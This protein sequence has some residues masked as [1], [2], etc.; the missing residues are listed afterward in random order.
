MVAYNAGAYTR[1]INKGT[2]AITT[3]IDTLSL[4]T[5]RQVPSQSR[6]YLYKMLGKD[7]FLSLLYQ[8]KAI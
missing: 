4:A 3:P 2:T 1:A 8:Q 6:D 5:N 7:G